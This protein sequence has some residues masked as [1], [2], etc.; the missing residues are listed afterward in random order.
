MAMSKPSCGLSMRNVK[1]QLAVA[2]LICGNF[3]VNI[4]EKWIDPCGD[5]HKDVAC[6]GIVPL[7]KQC[8][9]R[10]VAIVAIPS[11]K[12]MEVSY[13]CWEDGHF[14]IQN[15]NQYHLIS[16]DHIRYWW[17]WMLAPHLSTS[18]RGHMIW[19]EAP[20]LARDGFVLQ[21]DFLYG[22]LAEGARSSWLHSG[23][24]T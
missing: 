17:Y 19:R 2:A 21:S 4:L 24:L 14:P 16:F 1:A 23:N 10:D 12:T 13:S 6:F 15:I 22:N 3:L 18:S 7:K 9:L 20:G 5:K 8:R 11:F